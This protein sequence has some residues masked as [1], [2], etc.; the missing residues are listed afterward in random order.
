M[1]KNRTRELPT[2]RI[3]PRGLHIIAGPR[4]GRPYAHAGCTSGVFRAV[5]CPFCIYQHLRDIQE[6]IPPVKSPVS[7]TTIRG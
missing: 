6:D 1:R 7:A 5:E 2:H 3:T 4:G